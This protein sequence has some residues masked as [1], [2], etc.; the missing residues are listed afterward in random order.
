MSRTL[1]G[2]LDHQIHA[3]EDPRR[4]EQINPG[5]TVLL[6]VGELVFSFLVGRELYSLLVSQKDFAA[7]EEEAYIKEEDGNG[8]AQARSFS[9]GRVVEN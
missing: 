3:F 2:V 9:P 6:L 4:R 8:E 1:C 5:L 7:K